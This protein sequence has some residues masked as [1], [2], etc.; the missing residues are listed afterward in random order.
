LQL[1]RIFARRAG[2]LLPVF[3]VV[4]IPTSAFLFFALQCF[5]SAYFNLEL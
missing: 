2:F 3:V 1:T 4:V 5:R